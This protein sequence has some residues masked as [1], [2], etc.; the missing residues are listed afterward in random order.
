MPAAGAA[1]VLIA[2]LAGGSKS[3]V[4]A[5]QGDAKGL[6]ELAR[7]F[8]VDPA[9]CRGGRCIGPV[10]R[11]DTVL[12]QANRGPKQTDLGNKKSSIC[13]KKMMCSIACCAVTLCHIADIYIPNLT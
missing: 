6:L 7:S 8:Q 4:R 11:Q 5:A 2:A 10:H 13:S 9:V 3:G 1:A 12:H